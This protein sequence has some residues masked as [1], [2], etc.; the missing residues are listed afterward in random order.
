MRADQKDLK[1]LL[2]SYNKIVNNIFMAPS[3]N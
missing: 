2:A 1:L 3:N